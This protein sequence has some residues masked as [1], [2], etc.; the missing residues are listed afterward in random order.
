MPKSLVETS[1]EPS[2]RKGSHCQLESVVR[3]KETRQKKL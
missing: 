1:D 2:S 3:A